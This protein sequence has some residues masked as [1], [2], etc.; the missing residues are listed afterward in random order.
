MLFSIPHHGGAEGGEIIG[1]Y[2]HES[3]PNDSL[4]ALNV[5]GATPY[6][7]PNLRFVDM[8]GL[9]DDVIGGRDP[10]PMRSEWQ[11][12]PGHA[13][14]DGA[15]VLSREPDY[16]ILSGAGGSDAADGL[17]LGDIELAESDEF[18]TCYAKETEVLTDPG[19]Y[20]DG[21][22]IWPSL[23]FIYYRRIC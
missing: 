20:R 4:V 3:W 7:A 12:R 15:Y 17:F 16:I 22:V 23:P 1:N 8:L 5:A 21:P 13:K 14:G 10:V 6:Y 2:I 9:N 11:K 19:Q 18:R